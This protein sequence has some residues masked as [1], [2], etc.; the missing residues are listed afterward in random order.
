MRQN[1]LPFKIDKVVN[2]LTFSALGSESSEKP[3][4]S[5]IISF[6]PDKTK[7]ETMAWTPGHMGPSALSLFK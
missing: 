5:F 1:Q 4:V 2:H 7:L 3:G 6:I